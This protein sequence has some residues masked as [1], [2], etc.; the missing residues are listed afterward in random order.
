MTRNIALFAWAF[1]GAVQAA[2][3]QIA[4]VSLQFASADRAQALWLTNSGNAPLHAQVRVYRWTQTEDEDMLDATDALL[5][6]P[7]LVEI[8][9]GQRQLVRIVRRSLAGPSDEESYRLIV[10]ELPETL[11]LADASSTGSMAKSERPNGLRLLL[12]YSVPVFLAG[13]QPA[14]SP[15]LARITGTWTAAPVPSLIVQNGGTRR[16]R[17]SQVVHEDS[18][19]RRTVLVP[20]LLG[21]VLAGQRRR[22]QIPAAQTAQGELG[23]GVIKARLH[24]APQ[25]FPVATVGR[26]IP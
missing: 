21:Y 5:P 13:Q 19:G 1:L 23:P 3:L 2:D 24:E 4:P 20:G 16:L 8:A 9:P 7:P 22:W 18:S 12:R 11:P 6:S 17:I 26:S 25:E 15:E 10:D 14:A